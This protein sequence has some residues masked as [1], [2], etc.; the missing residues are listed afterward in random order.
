[1]TFLFPWSWRPRELALFFSLS[2]CTSNCQAVCGL[3][4]LE[5]PAL[6]SFIS[7]L[8]PDLGHHFNIDYQLTFWRVPVFSAL[9]LF[10]LSIITPV[11]GGPFT[12]GKLNLK[13]VECSAQDHRSTGTRAGPHLFAQCVP[14]FQP[15]APL[16][17]IFSKKVD[18]WLSQWDGHTIEHTAWKSR[19]QSLTFWVQVLIYHRRAMWL[20]I[21]NLSPVFFNFVWLFEI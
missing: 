9:V 17:K 21:N 12:Q 6:A 7:M 13:E 4:L 20:W 10:S 5:V 11:W 2:P 15:P 19:Q 3:F 8:P 18:S 14:I 1:M 16:V